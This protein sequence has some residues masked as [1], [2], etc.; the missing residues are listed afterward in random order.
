MGILCCPNSSP[1]KPTVLDIS[2]LATFLAFS[3]SYLC[4]HYTC[5]P[6]RHDLHVWG[7]FLAFSPSSPKLHLHIHLFPAGIQLY[8]LQH[9]QACTNTIGL[10]TLLPYQLIKLVLKLIIIRDAKSQLPGLTNFVSKLRAQ[11]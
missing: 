10:P 1:C 9:P 8:I 5:F 3:I 11:K 4:P 6:T 2:S 7:F